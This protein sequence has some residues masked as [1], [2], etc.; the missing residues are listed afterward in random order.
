MSQKEI[1]NGIRARDEYQ[2][3][4]DRFHSIRENILAMWEQTTALQTNER[5]AL[6]HKMHVL[7]ELERSFITDIKTGE[8]AEKGA[9][10]ARSR[11]N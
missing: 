11:T 7:K 6:Y 3:L 10:N 9:E 4:S 5:E 2:S 8:L 1:E